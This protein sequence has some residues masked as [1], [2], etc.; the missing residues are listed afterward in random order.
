MEEKRRADSWADPMTQ[1]LEW[2]VREFVL[3]LLLVY[4]WKEGR[5]EKAREG[6]KS[7]VASSPCLSAIVIHCFLVLGFLYCIAAPHAASPSYAP[8]HPYPGPQSTAHLGCRSCG[9]F[10]PHSRRHTHTE[11][12]EIPPPKQKT[13]HPIPPITHTP[14][15]PPVITTRATTHLPNLPPLPPP[16]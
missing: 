1:F 5:A 10:E 14:P 7:T 11:K 4:P 6:K 3:I 8:P 9:C 2:C 12:E 16:P 13:H 15:T